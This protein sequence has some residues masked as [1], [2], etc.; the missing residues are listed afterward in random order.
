MP[1]SNQTPQID[2][3]GADGMGNPSRIE[4]SEPARKG[5]KSIVNVLPLALVRARE[6]V[7]LPFRNLLRRYDLTEPQ[8]RVLRT[9][10]ELA[11]IELTELSR[12]TAL[13][14]PSLSRIVREL[15]VRGYM[16]RQ[17]DTHDMRRTL[18][19]LT[20]RGHRLVDI[21]LPDCE[22][23]YVA[24]KK[25]MSAEKLKL[26][27]SLLLE[28]ETKLAYLDV[29]FSEKHLPSADAIAITPPKQRG[30]PPKRP[31]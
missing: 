3:N 6:S 24:I 8:F 19:R 10:A 30:R 7:M 13:L 2:I 17:A 4:P 20:D 23:V 11:D 29:S 22:T 27:Q 21:V 26:L 16:L 15:E 18:V 1:A 25:T 14:M 28:F 5:R 31:D 12:V 9:V